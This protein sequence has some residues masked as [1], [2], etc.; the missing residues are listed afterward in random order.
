MSDVEQR[1]KYLSYLFFCRD[2]DVHVPIECTWI[3]GMNVYLIVSIGIY[4]GVDAGEIKSNQNVKQ[5]K[6]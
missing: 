6:K 5:I 1:V 3:V 2:D 4:V